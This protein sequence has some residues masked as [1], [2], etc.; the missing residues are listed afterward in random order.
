MTHPRIAFAGDFH[1]QAGS[2]HM[3]AEY[4]RA[5]SAAGCEVR[6]S[7]KLSRLDG[8]ID[9]HLPLVDDLGW[10]THLVV[11]FEGRQFLKP[12]QIDMCDRVPR[13]RRAV[14]DPDAHWGEHVRLGDD[15]S[16]GPLGH[17]EWQDLYRHL[18]D[19]VL[20]PRLGALPEG[21]T[22]FTYFGM[23]EPVPARQIEV[24]LQYVGA[25]WWRWQE[26]TTLFDAAR[27]VFARL[28]VRGRWWD[29]QPHPDHPRATACVPSWFHD[30]KVEVGPP[31]PFGHVV[32][33]MA[34][35]ALTPVLARPLLAQQR[36]LTPRMFETL[37][38]TGTLPVF[39]PALT[40][41]RS[42]YGD[43][44][45]PF[46]LG[47]DLGEHLRRLHLDAPQHQAAATA[48]R[49]DLHRRFNYHAVLSRLA[50]LFD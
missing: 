6:V 35:A 14:I 10:A 8:Q 5:A 32:G 1:W 25:N 20:Q 28:R 11:V 41:T 9:A 47:D 19:L 12:D 30:R 4:A 23:P 31:V 33:A 46:V 50:A 49:K 39:S 18:A 24:D 48:I 22:F 15:D 16:A 3:I 42:L 29:T 43:A 21:A 2:S 44:I 34:E 36:L 40:Y 45:D 13:H 7:S 27:P 26:I 37:A 17:T 38:A